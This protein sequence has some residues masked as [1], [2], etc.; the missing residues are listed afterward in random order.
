MVGRQGSD[1]RLIERLL[2]ALDVLASGAHVVELACGT[3][4]LSLELARRRGD[5]RV[6]ATDIDPMVMDAGRAVVRLEGLAVGFR[7]MDP[8]RLAFGD[9]SV[10]AIICSLGLLTPSEVAIQEAARVLR[11]GGL[12]VLAVTEGE[13]ATLEKFLEAADFADVRGDRFEW[14]PSGYR[15]VQ[16]T[17][18]IGISDIE[19]A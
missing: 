16:M 8:N 2:G 19:T 13:S 10:D 6:T 9:Q 5:L 1:T 15:G 11:P 12:L 3:G 4:D 17:A 7:R 18:R 14:E